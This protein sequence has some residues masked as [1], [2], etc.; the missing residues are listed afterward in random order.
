MRKEE[1][2]EKANYVLSQAQYIYILHKINVKIG[3]KSIMN[4]S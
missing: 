3:G 1:V 2:K 4:L